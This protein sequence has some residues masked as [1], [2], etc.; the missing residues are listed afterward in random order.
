MWPAGETRIE[1]AGT[2]L[3]FALGVALVVKGGDLFVSSSVAI[4]A[5]A[6]LP[7]VLIG[8][9]LV[10]LATTAPELTVS[11]TASFRG[12]SGLA[13]GNAVG[14]AIANIGLI[15]GVLCLLHPL[16]VRA[17]DFRVPAFVMLGA[18]ILLT[19]LTIPLRLERWAGGLLLA[20]GLAFLAVDYLRHRV[21]RAEAQENADTPTMG[22]R[23]AGV[24]FAIGA[25]T[26]IGGSRLL[27][28]NGVVLARM[29]G[30]PPMVIGLSLVAIGTSLP[31]LVTAITAARKGVPDLSLGNVLGANILN[32]TLVSGLAATIRP[33]TMTRGMQLYNFPAMLAIFILLLVLARTGRRLTRKEGG[34][35]LGVYVLYLVGLFML[36][37]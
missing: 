14:S 11:A 19:V 15:L 12:Q 20:C 25:A 21:G 27:C 23:K 22:L 6:R 4:A 36:P 29:I 1:T 18:G 16:A 17:R 7:R 28:D 13:I 31:E 26:V 32:V 35:L 30:I 2:I 10:S 34:I 37:K 24:M 5:H 8:S 9:T 3:L 33:L